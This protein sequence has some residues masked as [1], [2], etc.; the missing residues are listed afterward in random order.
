MSE[1]EGVTSFEEARDAFPMAVTPTWGKGALDTWR[2]QGGD[3][4][5]CREKTDPRSRDEFV[6]KPAMMGCM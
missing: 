6:G 4:T 1:E 2:S 3:R 5:Q